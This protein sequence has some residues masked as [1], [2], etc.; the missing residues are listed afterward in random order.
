[1]KTAAEVA[2]EIARSTP[3]E[4]RRR[5]RSNHRIY[6]RVED[7]PV[8][9]GPSINITQAALERAGYS[10]GDPAALLNLSELS[11]LENLAI[12]ARAAVKRRK[13]GWPICPRCEEDELTSP[14]I[15]TTEAEKTMARYLAHELTCLRCGFR[16]P[17]GVF[18]DMGV[19]R[20]AEGE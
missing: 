3:A 12:I 20:P 16:A 17:P 2:D 15:P 10:V 9:G 8:F 1:L 5:W 7:T 18:L 6:G 19:G 14:F 4:L 13:D 11:H